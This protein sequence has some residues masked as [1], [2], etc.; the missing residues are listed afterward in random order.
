MTHEVRNICIFWLQYMY[1]P[2][3]RLLKRFP[4]YNASCTSM[5]STWRR[6]HTHESY[7]EAVKKCSMAIHR[8]WEA[9]TKPGSRGRNITSESANID[10]T[11]TIYRQNSAREIDIF[12]HKNTTGKSLS[13]LRQWN[14]TERVLETY[15]IWLKYYC[16]GSNQN[17]GSARNHVTLDL[18]QFWLDTHL[19]EAPVHDL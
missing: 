11:P 4:Y 1:A 3:E 8:H 7:S 19:L 14:S 2:N 17:L 12:L 10:L 18:Y 5:T 9:I 13:I 15:L 16:A 6:K